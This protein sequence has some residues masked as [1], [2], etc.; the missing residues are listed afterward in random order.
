MLSCWV[1]GPFFVYLELLS[2]KKKFIQSYLSCVYSA[3]FG[4]LLGLSGVPCTEFG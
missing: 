3:L 1:H 4:E 2:G